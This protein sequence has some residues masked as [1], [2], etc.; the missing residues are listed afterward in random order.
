MAG[1]LPGK[2]IPPGGTGSMRDIRLTVS[3][4]LAGLPACWF[5]SLFL[6]SDPDAVTLYT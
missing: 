5:G 2:T 1:N 4:M 6:T 3:G